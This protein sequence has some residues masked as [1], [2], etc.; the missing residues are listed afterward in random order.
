MIHAINLHQL[1]NY[2]HDARLSMALMMRFSGQ[3]CGCAALSGGAN[4]IALTLFSFPSLA[5]CER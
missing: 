3:H 2:E 5:K 4:N 1:A